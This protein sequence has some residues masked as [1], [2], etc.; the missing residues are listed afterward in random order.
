MGEKPPP[1]PPGTPGVWGITDVFL[2]EKFEPNQPFFLDQ[3]K[4]INLLIGVHEL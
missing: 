3:K 2:K 4:L 1:P